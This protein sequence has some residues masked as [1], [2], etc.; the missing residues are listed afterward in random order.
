MSSTQPQRAGG[1]GLHPFLQHLQQLGA[2]SVVAPNGWEADDC[3]GAICA[4]LEGEL[5][6]DTAVCRTINEVWP[7]LVNT[8]Y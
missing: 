2:I 3:V 8:C 1:A 4:E 6:T 7:P 5:V